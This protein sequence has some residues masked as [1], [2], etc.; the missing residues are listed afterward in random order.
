MKDL[1]GINFDARH[2]SPLLNCLLSILVTTVDKNCSTFD[3]ILQADIIFTSKSR[4][5]ANKLVHKGE[6]RVAGRNP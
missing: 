1:H 5:K 2:I 4:K 6:G 3:I